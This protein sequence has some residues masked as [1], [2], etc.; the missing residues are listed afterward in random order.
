MEAGQG[1]V[2]NLETENII[3]GKNT[4]VNDGLFLAGTY[5]RGQIVGLKE[6][7]SAAGSVKVGGNTGNATIGDVAAGLQRQL[8]TY[9]IICVTATTAGVYAP[10][11]AYLGLL[12]F[13]TLFESPQ[14]E[15]KITAGATPC[16]AG[17]GFRVIV[18]S[19]A[20]GYATYNASLFDGAQIP[21]AICMKDAVLNASGYL[22][23]G[24][25]EFQYTGVKN[26]MAAL[27]APISMSETLVQLCAL[28]GIYLKRA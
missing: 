22:P 24:F 11:G 9:N 13:G 2:A 28:V 15:L 14:V 21:A 5:K 17:D 8:G 19:T 23:I 20:K 6:T 10:D 27:T 7:V 4:V 25:G 16:I 26:I 12:T 3:A 1:V 18:T